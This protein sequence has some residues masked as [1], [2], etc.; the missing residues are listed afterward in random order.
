MVCSPLTMYT[1]WW[2]LTFYVGIVCSP[3]RSSVTVKLMSTL[4]VQNCAPRPDVQRV[5]WSW[6]R[7]MLKISWDEHLRLGDHLSHS[8]HNW[9]MLLAPFV[10]S[11]MDGRGIFFLLS[12][13]PGLPWLI[14]YAWLHSFL[15]VVCISGFCFQLG[16]NGVK[17]FRRD[18]RMIGALIILAESQKKYITCTPWAQK[19]HRFGG[20]EYSMFM[21]MVACGDN[22]N[23]WYGKFCL[24]WR[25]RISSLGGFDIGYF[26]S[27]STH[28]IIVWTTFYRFW[29]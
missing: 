27:P 7:R 5:A 23:D 22:R 16:D 10:S 12:Y 17:W 24:T 20:N 4:C 13:S 25:V 21:G 2:V 15:S 14:F 11:H 18:T 9:L 28:P 8:L 1:I 19:W 3:W 29:I 6:T 26:I